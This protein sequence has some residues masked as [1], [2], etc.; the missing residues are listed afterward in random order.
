M[1][2]DYG[3]ILRLDLIIIF[4]EF[5]I[6]FTLENILIFG[7]LNY[8][9]KTSLMVMEMIKKIVSKKEK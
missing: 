1:M 5:G 7:K 3:F 9:E 2:K 6:I 4:Q 8:Y